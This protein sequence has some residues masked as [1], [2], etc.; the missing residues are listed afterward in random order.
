MTR[1]Y[2]HSPWDKT[3]VQEN[4]TPLRIGDKVRLELV[5]RKTG[6]AEPFGLDVYTIGEGNGELGI[7]GFGN[8]DAWFHKDFRPLREFAHDVGF[9]LVERVGV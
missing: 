6:E 3:T 1:T 5:N 4:D 8:P 2:Q 9:T 7:A